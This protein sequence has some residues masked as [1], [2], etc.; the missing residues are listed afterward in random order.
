MP[1]DGVETAPYRVLLKAN[2]RAQR[3]VEELI[4]LNPNFVIHVGD[5]VRPFPALSNY[6]EVC[7][8][9]LELFQQLPCPVHYIPGNHDI[10]DKPIANAPAP[11]ICDAFIEKYKNKFGNTYGSFEHQGI[12]FILL[13]SSVINSGL[14]EEHDQW[15]WLDQQSL[16]L[17]GKRAFMFIH[18]PPYLVSTEEHPHYDNI[19]E[20]GRTRLLT[21]IN[22]METEALFAGHVHHYFYNRHGST[23]MYCL[24]A[25]SFTRHDF[26]ELFAIG[27]HA[28]AEFGRDDSAKLGYAIVDVYADKHV[29]RIIN[30]DGARES[31]NFNDRVS[32][33]LLSLH[34]RDGLAPPIA[35][36]LRHIWNEVRALPNNGPLDDFNRKKARNDYPILAT[37]QMGISWLRVPLQ[38]LE[39]EQTRVRM[40]ALRQMGQRFIVMKF[41]LPDDETID[42]VCK[43][44]DLV[45]AMEII[46]PP[47]AP[48]TITSS[49]GEWRDKLKIPLYLGSMESSADLPSANAK[50]FAHSTNFGCRVNEPT[51]IDLLINRQRNLLA[52]FDGVLFQIPSNETILTQVT[53]INALSTRINK[54]AMVH[55][56]MATQ[57]PTTA[58]FDQQWVANRTACA[59]IAALSLTN[60][61]V[62]LDSLTDIDRGDFPRSGLIDRRGNINLAG[63]YLRTLLSVLVTSAD[64]YLIEIG[65]T[66]ETDA[67]TCVSFRQGSQ[68][69]QLYLIHKGELAVIEDFGNGIE[70]ATL[71][72]D[73]ETG[74]PM[75]TLGKASRCKAMLAQLED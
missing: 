2:Q 22:E 27:P 13:N 52:A 42:L 31:S 32:P 53:D 39:D 16:E 72:I 36:Q 56:M 67:Y 68:A 63:Q 25:T 26:S 57:Q 34:P 8:Q 41:G 18:Y 11:N 38:D 7:D 59:C 48:N 9:A 43:H 74:Q 1:N 3:V 60:G 20:P 24:P 65:E 5:M 49:L 70:Q 47:H 51:H 21:L 55:V 73:L 45:G 4:N 61:I 54:S 23:D 19:D 14:Q 10:G 64:H 37:W 75:P 44:A 29:V 71:C 33:P 40:Q 17:D 35:V 66:V 12:K 46:I 50:Y 62:I 69:Y 6:D 15:R 28:D 30:S 58:Q